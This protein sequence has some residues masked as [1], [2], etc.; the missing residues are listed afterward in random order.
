MSP[1]ELPR[2]TARAKRSLSAA[3]MATAAMYRWLRCGV[4]WKVVRNH[5]HAYTTNHNNEN[6]KRQGKDTLSLLGCLGER[7]RV[8]G[9]EHEVDLAEE[10]A[11][12]VQLV[13]VRDAVPVLVLE[14]VRLVRLAHL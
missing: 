3:T 5:M 11:R 7:L 1:R 2:A 13:H 9:D 8:D 6:A 10:E 12:G 4:V 14:R